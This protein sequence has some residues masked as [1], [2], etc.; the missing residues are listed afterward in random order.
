MRACIFKKKKKNGNLFL[1]YSL[2]T[3]FESQS[4]GMA[5]IWCEQIHS[6]LVHYIRLWFKGKFDRLVLNI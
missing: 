3:F 1:R 4:R 2:D 6:N 5:R